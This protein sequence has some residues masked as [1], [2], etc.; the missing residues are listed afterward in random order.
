[1]KIWRLAN[2]HDDAYARCILRGA[3]ALQHDGGGI[4]SEC[5][6]SAY[7]RVPPLI[8]EWEPG[9]NVIGDFNWPDA[10]Q[11]VAVTRHA[12]DLL[13]EHFRG[14]SAGPVQM[15]E[16]PQL[17]AETDKYAGLRVRL[18]YDGPELYEL[19]ID[20]VVGVD[21]QRSS[22]KQKLNCKVCGSTIYSVEGVEEKKSRWNRT[23]MKLEPVEHP[24]EPGKGLYIQQ[25]KLL[26]R[27]IFRTQEFPSWILCT[28]SVR[29][30][31]VARRFSNISFL[32]YGETFR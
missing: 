3:W 28:D 16:E 12:F 18:P 7:R 8:L 13:S 21:R 15:T 2:P 19:W 10:G 30:L 20:A 11:S 23:T 1:M 32:E 9:S 27:E 26:E 29:E 14:F 25:K 24:R 5:G 22:I 4:C 6:T 31:M 17:P